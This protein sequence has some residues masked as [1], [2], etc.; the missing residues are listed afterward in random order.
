MEILY[1]KKPDIAS[2]SYNNFIIVSIFFCLQNSLSKKSKKLDKA[3]EFLSFCATPENY[4]YAFDRISTVSCFKGQTTNI[5]SKMVTE[6]A[7]SIGAKERVS[8][9][10]AKIVGYSAE[11]VAAA[12][13]SLFD[14]AVDVKGCVAEMDRLRLADAQKQHADK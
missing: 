10:V 5:E 8:T 13:N 6:A 12:V 14:G 7:A 2:S 3:K 9:A 11:D 4:N 1:H